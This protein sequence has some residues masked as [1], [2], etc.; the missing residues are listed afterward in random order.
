MI[1]IAVS[2]RVIVL[3][4]QD[5]RG[6]CLDHD[7]WSFLCECGIYPVI[8]PNHAETARR[9]LDST[10]IA[11]IL[12]TGGNDL[13]AYG[14]DAPE[15]DETESLLLNFSIER[16]LP[17]L[18]VCRGM[19]FIQHQFGVPLSK[20]DG[21]VAVSQTILYKDSR[22]TVNSYHIW[23][24]KKTVPELEVFAVSLDGVT[25][26]IRHSNLPIVCIMW[27]PERCK[28]I[29]PEDKNLFQSHFNTD[30]II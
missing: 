14:G 25:K 5:V 20:V 12:L 19:Q 17:L 29:D 9:I 4:H 16:S 7:W 27:H 2:Q 1:R 3:P 8:I 11:G 30:T 22:R 10:P 15:R 26:A 24:S 28:P 18:G 6:D 21:H 23:G 13:L